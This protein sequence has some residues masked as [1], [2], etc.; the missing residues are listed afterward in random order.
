ME[1]FSWYPV[2]QIIGENLLGCF[3]SIVL[4]HG[5]RF[6]IALL[7]PKK[8]SSK[9][10]VCLGLG[11]KWKSLF[12]DPIETCCFTIWL[13][14]WPGSFLQFYPTVESRLVLSDNLTPSPSSSLFQDL[15]RVIFGDCPQPRASAVYTRILASLFPDRLFWIENSGQNC[16]PQS[17]VVFAVYTV[18]K[19]RPGVT[20]LLLQVDSCSESRV[21]KFLI[22]PPL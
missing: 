21:K 11:K 6:H 14:F 22:L 18:V 3:E 12:L 10:I 13:T 19:S 20:W 2:Q 8:M 16:S 7:Y 15:R 17:I 9:L 1:F 5:N 4:V